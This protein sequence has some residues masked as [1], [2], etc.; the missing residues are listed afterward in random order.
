MQA[1]ARKNEQILR[2]FRSV[3][4]RNDLAPFRFRDFL[5]KFRSIGGGKFSSDPSD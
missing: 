3:P 4:A 5:K 2:D 1:L